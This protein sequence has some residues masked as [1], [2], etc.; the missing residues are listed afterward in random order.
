[1]KQPEHESGFGLTVN[2]FIALFI[3]AKTKKVEERRL[4]NG[5]FLLKLLSTI[6]DAGDNE[7]KIKDKLSSTGSNMN[8]IAGNLRNDT[9]P[10]PYHD[11]PDGIKMTRF[12]KLYHSTRPDSGEYEY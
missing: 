6:S 4:G 3:Q 11:M 10:Y 8:N 2:T 9:K 7:E 5:K 12:E 1:M